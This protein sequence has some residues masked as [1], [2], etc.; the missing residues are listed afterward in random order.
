MAKIV[1]AFG[2]PHNPHFPTWSQEG[3]PLGEEIDRYYG[4]VAEQLR[5]VE[6]DAI[7]YFTSDHYN[8][9]FESVPIFS[10]AVAPS[11]SG[12]SDYPTIARRELPI[13]SEL[14]RAVQRH[15][16]ACNFDVGMLQ[17]LEFDHT[18]IAPL[19]FLLPDRDIPLVPVYISAF[20]RPIPSAQRCY[21]LGQAIREAIEAADAPER[22]AVIA[23]GSFS[24]E[25]G[26][27]RLAPDSHVGVPDPTWT[28]R[29]V[30]LLEAGDFTRLVEEATDAQMGEAGN[31]AGELL[32][33]IAMLGMIDPAA[34]AFVEPQP[35]FGHSFAAW[36][37]DSVA[38]GG[39]T[40]ASAGKIGRSEASGTEASR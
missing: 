33:W 37:T 23:S 26:G 4:R 3:H 36:P 2:V 39:R 1:G 17:E 10:I 19:H 14:A 5:A 8:L 18:V 13:A 30:E 12:P 29:V 35:Q 16:M 6:P 38:E 11:A 31:A 21:A 9:F 32:D 34:P 25:I 24:V 7:V 27:P 40:A 20:L 22:V 28:Q 15:V